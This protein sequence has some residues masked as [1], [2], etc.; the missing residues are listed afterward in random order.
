MKGMFFIYFLL[1]MYICTYD[2]L[3]GLEITKL[4]DFASVDIDISQSHS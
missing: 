1:C 2:K 4:V 3:M